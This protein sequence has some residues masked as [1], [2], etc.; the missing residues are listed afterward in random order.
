MCSHAPNDFSNL[1]LRIHISFP[2]T[3]VQAKSGFCFATPRNAESKKNTDGKA[4]LN[5]NN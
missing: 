4:K 1:R 5:Q 2:A 3:A